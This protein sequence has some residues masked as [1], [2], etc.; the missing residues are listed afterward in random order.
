MIITD[1]SCP[2]LFVQRP[3]DRL[4]AL[5]MTLSEY[6]IK[7]ALWSL[8]TCRPASPHQ[9]TFAKLLRVPVFCYLGRQRCMCD[10]WRGKGLRLP[11]WSTCVTA[12]CFD[13]LE[14]LYPHSRPRSKRRS[15][16]RKY[17]RWTRISVKSV[18]SSTLV[19]PF[20]LRLFPSKKIYTP[21]NSE[22][23]SRTKKVLMSMWQ[24]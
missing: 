24:S 10:L 23:Y 17:G 3:R 16:E 11:F 4:P 5:S 15:V 2:V 21:C 18:C 7:L 6:L 1:A 14:M 12:N 19:F 20:L 8:R 22:V 13:L 9:K